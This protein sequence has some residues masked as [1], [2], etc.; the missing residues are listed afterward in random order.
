MKTSIYI[1]KEN[2]ERLKA[3]LQGD[4][5]LSTSSIINEALDAYFNTETFDCAELRKLRTWGLIK[6]RVPLIVIR[7]LKRL[8]DNFD[9]KAVCEFVAFLILS[10]INQQKGRRKYPD[11]IYSGWE[12]LKRLVERVTARTNNI[13]KLEK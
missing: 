12:Y 13:E 4:K 6:V 11:R 8:R 10:E 5:G 7:L 1:N 2:E 3:L 9:V